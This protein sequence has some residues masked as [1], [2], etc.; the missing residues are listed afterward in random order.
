[1]RLDHLLS[2]ETGSATATSSQRRDQVG[3]RASGPK[4]EGRAGFK[5]PGTRRS[6]S[7][8]DTE[9]A[10]QNPTP[11]PNVTSSSSK[12]HIKKPTVRFFPLSSVKVP[13]CE[14]PTT[15][16]PPRGRGPGR[17]RI[18]TPRHLTPPTA[19]GCSSVGR[20]PLLH[21]GGQGFE[22]PQL[23][24]SGPVVG[25]LPHSAGR[26]PTMCSRLGIEVMTYL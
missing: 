13:F 23:H 1:M 8:K 24:Q 20:A 19:W 12:T 3:R 26:C 22:S 9:G 18:H 15:P 2:R 25:P 14:A 10:P 4:A 16:P 5:R 6:V 17:G 11:A 21:S 7:P